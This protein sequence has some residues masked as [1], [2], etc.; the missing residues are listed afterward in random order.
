VS[1][2]FEF[3]QQT[4]CRV[5]ELEDDEPGAATKISN[6]G[7][8]LEV[9]SGMANVNSRGADLR[10][11]IAWAAES[12][13]R[14]DAV[15]DDD[16][17]LFGAVAKGFSGSD[18]IDKFPDETAR[19]GEVGDIVGDEGAKV[20]SKGPAG[21]TEDLFPGVDKRRRPRR[22]ARVCHGRKSSTETRHAAAAEIRME[23]VEE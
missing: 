9:I 7:L 18:V 8:P 13:H 5:A 14:T 19:C 16:E 23:R 17:A 22:R 4:G 10:E 3:P 6:R 2:I 20:E 21:F 12:D 15:G 1:G 11:A